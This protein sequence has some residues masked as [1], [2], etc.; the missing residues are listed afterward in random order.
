MFR[1]FYIHA[2]ALITAYC[3]VSCFTTR[4]VT[5]ADRSI[6][7]WM[8]VQSDSNQATVKLSDDEK[9][10][11]VESLQSDE[12]MWG[13]EGIDGDGFDVDFDEFTVKHKE[14]ELNWQQSY[15]TV[16]RQARL[17]SKPILMWFL[18]RS[19]G[20]M[21]VEMEREIFNTNRFKDWA[22]DEVILMKFEFDKDKNTADQRNY[23]EKA[24]KHFNIYGLPEILVVDPEQ[25]VQARFQ[26]FQPGR[27]RFLLGRIQGAVDRTVNKIK[28]RQEVLIER[29][30]RFY[31]GKNDGS[32]FAKLLDYKVGEVYMV[33]PSGRRFKFPLS[34]LSNNDQKRI[35]RE[36][37][38]E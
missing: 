21:S 11:L 7:A 14:R 10:T 26:G 29:G 38:V 3:L 22:S 31:K 25:E 16:R 18:D 5:K 24:K 15:A 12:T 23:L 6:P 35:K 9:Q 2:F 32:I 1:C 27:G 34:S 37:G 28:S 33:S 30:F 36:F 8:K 4:R 13:D 19:R 20:G 17:E